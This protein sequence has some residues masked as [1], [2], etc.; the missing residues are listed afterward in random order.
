MRFLWWLVRSQLGRV[1]AGAVLGTLW[2]VG[3][4]VA[5]YLIARAVD[6]GIRHGHSTALVSWVAALFV[7][8]VV[9]AVLGTA[10]HRTMTRIRMDASFQMVRAIMRQETKLGAGLA[11]RLTSGEV[12][13]VGVADVQ[14]ISQSLTVT[15]PGIGAVVAYIVVAVL[16]LSISGVL[17]LVI[18]AGVPLLAIAVGP[19]LRSLERLSSGYRAQLGVLTGRLV[20]MMTGLRVLSGLGGK[21]ALR[22]RYRRDSRV[23]RERGYE[24]G[25]VTSWI[26]ALAFGLP[27]IF[28]AVVTWLS[29]RMAAAHTISV[30]DLVAVTGYVAMLVVPVAAFIEGGTDITRAIVSARRTIAFLNLPVDHGDGVADV[31]SKAAVIRDPMSGVEIHEG[32]FIALAG[33]RPEDGSEI[34]DRLGRFAESDA[35]WGDVRLDQFRLAAVRE[36]I[37]VADNDADIFSGTLRE[38]VAGRR[39]GSD[40]QIREALEVAVATDVLDALPAGLDSTIMSNGR[41]LS[42]GQRQRVRLARAVYAAPRVLL[43]A[44]PTSAVDAH[45]DAAMAARLRSA[46]AGLTTVVTT[47]SPLVLDQSDVVVYLVDGRVAA[48]GSHRSLLDTEPGYRSLVARG[49]VAEA[50]G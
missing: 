21:D 40:D 25:G 18:L 41:N 48:V 38:V 24:L 35:T 12:V 37:L 33:T 20:D 27:A 39:P 49:A 28:L 50:V 44:E 3:L 47:T 23:L 22:D 2:T 11:R 13:A 7:M 19:L 15:G 26:G 45:T 32:R 31:P 9:N 46:R 4:A 14:T 42:G 5:P 34:L 8:G 1:T 10:R 29:V 30:G 17:A 36:A 6:D 43:A 16:L